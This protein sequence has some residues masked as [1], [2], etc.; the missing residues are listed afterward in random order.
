MY[1][2][3]TERDKFFHQDRLFRGSPESGVQ[4]LKKSPKRPFS[5][6]IETFRFKGFSRS[7]AIVKAHFE[8]VPETSFGS[9]LLAAFT[10]R[11]VF[12]SAKTFDN[13]CRWTRILRVQRMLFGRLFSSSPDS[14]SNVS[15][16]V[17]SLF[18]LMYSIDAF[19]INRILLASS[20]SI[21]VCRCR[22]SLANFAIC[23]HVYLTFSSGRTAR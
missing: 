1:A 5:W 15:E 7:V 3:A 2:P 11:V 23:Y 12:L 4:I 17:H 8:S 21:N 13:F 6:F 14:R 10:F 16:P 20:F 18:P 9:H 19:L 22:L